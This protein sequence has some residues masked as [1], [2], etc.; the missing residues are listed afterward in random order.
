MADLDLDGDLDIAVFSAEAHALLNDGDGRFVLQPQ[1]WKAPGGGD[2]VG[3]EVI[4]FNGDFLP[5]LLRIER[6]TASEV[7]L[8]PGLL[9]PPSTGL[10]IAPTG[11]RGRDKRTRSPA[12]GYGVTL[13]ARAGLREQSQFFTGQSGGFNQSPVPV[14]FGLGG[15]RQADYVRL[16]WPDGVAQVETAL[17]AGQQ[18]KVAELERKI[19]SCPVLFAWNGQRFEFVTDF[20]GVGGLGY[21][22][23][24][25]ESAPPQ[26]LEH[27]KIEPAQLVAKA[28]IYELRITEP[29][30]ETAYIDQL[31]LLVVDHPADTGVFPDERLAIRG[32][33]PTHELLVVERRLFPGRATDLE[34]RDCTDKIARVDRVYAYEPPL[35]RRFFGFCRPHTLE[36]DFGDQLAGV[37]T[38]QRVHLFINGS[39]EYPY[40]QTVYAAS[41]ARVGWEPIRIERRLPDGRW[42][43]IVPDAGAPGG[44]ARTMTV[45]L[46]GLATGPD[47]RLRLTSNLEIYYDQVFLGLT[48]GADRVRVH[49]LPVAEAELRRVGFAREYS[50]DGR[51]PLIYD[52]ELRDVTAPFHVLKGAYTRYGPVTDLLRAFDDQYVLVGPGD[53]IAVKFDGSK[54]PPLA[55]GKTR[56]FILVSHA[57]CKDM[58]LYT[59]SPQTLEPLP[60]RGMSRYPYPAPEHYPDTAEH[61]RFLEQYN[62]RIIE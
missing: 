2:L 25:G 1:F 39:I 58:D 20:A 21:F 59:A 38:N 8:L 52:Y 36:L 27:V 35:D 41:Q 57:Y 49:A 19:S 47:C 53:E 15:A 29:M 46:T 33:P 48:R 31:E 24:P 40:S 3:A 44:M 42:Q 14:V 26:V 51:L 5:D 22:V 55:E 34:G 56:S 45:D 7:V 4:D 9:T 10:S 54:L 30:E 11:M 13:T 23:A 28:G 43:T 50:P 62:T 16:L 37:S 12:T 32:P 18:H 6:G 61:R 17:A 60:F